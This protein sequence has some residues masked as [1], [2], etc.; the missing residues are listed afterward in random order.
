MLDVQT[1]QMFV[2]WVGLLQCRTAFRLLKNNCKNV[3]GVIS[4][5]ILFSIF[6]AIFPQCRAIDVRATVKGTL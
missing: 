6:T 1:L 5:T 4:A 3:C 2:M